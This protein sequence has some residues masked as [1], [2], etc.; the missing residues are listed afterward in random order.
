MVIIYVVLLD[1]FIVIVFILTIKRAKISSNTDRFRRIELNTYLYLLM[2]AH[3]EH[4]SQQRY[5]SRDIY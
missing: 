2:Y 4:V 1:H 3:N 5:I